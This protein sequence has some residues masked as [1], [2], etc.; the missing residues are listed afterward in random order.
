M[1]VRLLTVDGE[2]VMVT[3]VAIAIAWPRLDGCSTKTRS[4]ARLRLVESAATEWDAAGR[5]DEDLLRGARLT[6]VVTGERHRSRLTDIEIGFLDASAEN[7]EAESARLEQRA[8]HE[9]SRNRVLRG[10]ALGAAALLVAA[11]AAGGVAVVQGREAAV[12]AEDQRIEALVATSLS[13]RSTDLD[14]AALLAAEAYQR[15]PDDGRVRS[16]LWGVLTSAHGLLS[17]WRFDGAKVAAAVIPGTS[18]ALRV[19]QGTGDAETAIVDLDTTETLRTLDV[20]LPFGDFG[21]NRQLAVSADGST[22]VVQT[23]LLKNPGDPETCCVNHLQFIDLGTGEALPGSGVAP[24]RTTSMILMEPDG[25][26]AFL[27]NLVTTDLMRVDSRTG[28]ITASDPRALADL[29]GASRRTN[30]IAWA[31]ERRIAVADETGITVFNAATVEPLI[32]HTI[33]G[34]RAAT[35]MTSAGDVVV[36]SGPDGIALIDASSGTVEWIAAWPVGGECSWLAMDIVRGTIQCAQSG[37][38]TPL[39]MATGSPAGPPV[40][41]NTDETPMLTCAAPATS[42]S[43]STARRSSDPAWTD[44]VP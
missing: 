1:H 24:V 6:G 13:L 40:T 3:H 43:W 19:V 27:G 35:A 44:P 22:A 11:I 4:G 2:S 33:P 36:T 38:I 25:S 29:T 14:A 18:T 30:A 39:S 34:N 10:L 32:H 8:A 41:L 5:N 23:P 7:A 9:R 16:S 28:M 31:G 12:S 37:Q 26:G 21:N 42:F 20:D 17:N 15:W